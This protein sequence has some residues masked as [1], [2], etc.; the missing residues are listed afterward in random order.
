LLDFDCSVRR[1]DFTLEAA[2]GV[3]AA[4]ITALFGPSGCGKTTALR[5]IAGDLEPH[6]GRIALDGEVL[7][8]IERRVSVPMERRGIGWVFQEGRLFPHLDVRRNLDYAR[9]LGRDARAARVAGIDRDRVID[10][11]GVRGLLRRWPRELS[12]GERQRV[13]LGRALLSAPRLLLCDEP[14]ASLDVTRKREILLLLRQVRDEFRIP[15]VYVTHALPELLY[16]AD[17]AVLL[18]HGRVTASGPLASLAG[19]L[20]VPALAERADS[21]TLIEGR[22]IGL[23]AQGVQVDWHGTTLHVH[24]FPCLLGDS[25]RI[26]VQSQDV[27]VAAEKPRAI[28]VR[29][30][31]ETRV[32]A[33]ESRSPGTLQ[34]ELEINGQRL[35][36]AVTTSAAGELGLE[37]GRTVYALIKSVAIEAPAG[38]ARLERV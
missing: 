35:L 34:I 20:S 33:M 19:Q 27:I 38:L 24:A 4:G 32:F 15:I 3:R 31:L 12:G 14:L 26:Y 10:V 1:G 25:V 17:D 37:R 21:G 11:L 7:V 28:S 2:F 18:D 5:L 22:V 30:V 8:D 13:A 16:L 6:R 23:D 29:N 36:A 9:D